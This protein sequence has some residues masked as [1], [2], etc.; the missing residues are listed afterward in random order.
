[1]KTVFEHFQDSSGAYR[2][3]AKRKEVIVATSAVGY[4]KRFNMF[5]SLRPFLTSIAKS[6]YEIIKK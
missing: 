1:M 5:R 6:D 4:R 2:W 3:V